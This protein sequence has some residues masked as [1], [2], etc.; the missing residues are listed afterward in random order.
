MKHNQ[1]MD[2][3]NRMIIEIDEALIKAKAQIEYVDEPD[4]LMRLGFEED[5]ISG[6]LMRDE[7][8]K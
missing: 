1:V 6:D 4:E 3:L 7:V 8:N 5:T 2:I